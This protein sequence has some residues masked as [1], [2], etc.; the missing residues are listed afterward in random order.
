M[1]RRISIT[2]Q[3]MIPPPD[4]HWKKYRLDL[5][6]RREENDHTCNDLRGFTSH[7]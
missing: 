4:R 6:I 5:S 3:V 1:I 2:L 7:H